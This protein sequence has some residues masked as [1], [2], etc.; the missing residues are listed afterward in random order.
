M[1]SYIDWLVVSWLLIGLA[2]ATTSHVIAA[3]VLIAYFGDM[4][5]C[6]LFFRQAGYVRVGT[7]TVTMLSVI[8]ASLCHSAPA[9]IAAIDALLGRRVVKY[10]T[11]H[12]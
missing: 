2:L 3:L 10:K 6:L 1:V 9:N 5:Q 11:A 7:F 12:E 8:A 4:A